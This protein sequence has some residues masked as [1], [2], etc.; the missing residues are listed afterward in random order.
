MFCTCESEVGLHRH[1]YAEGDP[2]KQKKKCE[3]IRL[4]RAVEWHMIDGGN[5]L[6]SIGKRHSIDRKIPSG[7]K[8]LEMIEVE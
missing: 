8:L 2:N 1:F 5:G 7:G 6:Q 3:E 4:G